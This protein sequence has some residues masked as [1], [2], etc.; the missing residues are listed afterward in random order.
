[1]L[2]LVLAATVSGD[3]V[4]DQTLRDYRAVTLQGFTVLIAPE[5]QAQPLI[6][7]RLEWRLEDQ[8]RETRAALPP[9]ALRDLA[10]VRIWVLDAGRNVG[11]PRAAF[12][13]RQATP[14]DASN[15]GDITVSQPDAFV[16]HFAQ[17][18][19]MLHELAHAFDDRRHG[20]KN[21]AVQAAFTD[22]TR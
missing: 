3:A 18:N 17:Q 22:A 9:H 4:S 1:M 10:D 6:W 19:V 2:S 8:L 12:Y 20:M 11:D 16:E 7:D 13:L 5:I 14:G 21:T 15:R